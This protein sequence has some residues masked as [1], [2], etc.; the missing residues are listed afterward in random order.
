MQ[1][2]RMFLSFFLELFRVNVECFGVLV[3]VVHVHLFTRYDCA[4]CHVQHLPHAVHP[5]HVMLVRVR[6]TVQPSQPIGALQLATIDVIYESVVTVHLPCVIR[7]D[8][9]VTLE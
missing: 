2:Y 4:S 7:Y 9:I 6:W 3:A 1:L 5:V 8:V